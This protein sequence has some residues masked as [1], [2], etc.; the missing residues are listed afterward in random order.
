MDVL[1]E[2]KRV[3]DAETQA[4]A[5]MRDSLDQSFV[6]AVDMLFACRS[7]VIVVGIGKSGMIGRKIAA[8]LSSTGTTS[9]FLHPAEGIHGDLGMVTKEDVIVIISNSG[10]TEEILKIIPN[11][12]RMGN[13]IILITSKPKSA[14]AKHSDIVLDTHSTEEAD[15]LKIAPTTSTTTALAMGDALASVLILKKG[16]K[17]EDFALLHPG[18]TLGKKLLLT[19]DDVMHKE[20]ANAIISLKASMKEAVVEI[21]T[22]GLGATSVVNEEGKLVGII[23]DGDLRRAIEKFDNLLSKRVDEVMTKGP[24][25]VQSGKLAV[26]A[27]RIMEDRPKQIMVLPVVN[28]KMEPVGMVRIHD[29]VIAGVA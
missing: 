14:L 23:T 7:R 6:D 2:A 21:S 29:L 10:E 28:S 13:K 20:E 1:T 16:F 25:V 22:K 8:T 4:L 12:K 27:V 3:L 5:V 19:I 9:F 18:G 15:P 26:E 24:L 11:L 17:K